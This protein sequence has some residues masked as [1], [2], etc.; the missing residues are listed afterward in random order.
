MKDDDRQKELNF[1]E[2]EGMRERG[3]DREGEGDSGREK[4][5]WDELKKLSL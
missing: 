1:G 3:G 4:R 5:L 2:K